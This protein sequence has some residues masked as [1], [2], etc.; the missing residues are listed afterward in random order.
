MPGVDA[1]L[2]TER[3]RIFCEREFPFIPKAVN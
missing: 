1:D 3:V 2:M